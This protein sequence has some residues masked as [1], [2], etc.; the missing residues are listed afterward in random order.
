MLPDILEMMEAS[1]ERWYD[2]NVDAN[3]IATCD[4]GRCF[5]ISDGITMS[6]NPY[7]RLICPN[8]ADELWT[9]KAEGGPD[10]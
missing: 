5:H 2:E 4:C 3:G 1:A 8:C 7:S 10:A 6:E 9:G